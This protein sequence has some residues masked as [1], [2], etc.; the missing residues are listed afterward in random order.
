MI[1]NRCW[2]DMRRECLHG[3]QRA[4]QCVNACIGQDY[5]QEAADKWPNVGRQVILMRAQMLAPGVKNEN[6]QN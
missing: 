2:R 1:W 3:S 6:E 5:C 4:S